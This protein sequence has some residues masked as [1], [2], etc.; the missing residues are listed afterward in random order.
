[1]E[2][3]RVFLLIILLI[4]FF[5]TPEIRPPT[6]SQREEISRRLEEDKHA[7]EVLAQSQYGDLDINKWLNITGF[8]DVDGYGWDRFLEVKQRAEAIT[9]AAIGQRYWSFYKASDQEHV[10]SDS[11]WREEEG[12]LNEKQ[13]PRG[14]EEIDSQQAEE[15]IS[16]DN[17][18][19]LYRNVTGI[20]HGE[21]MRTMLSSP[22]SPP[23]INFTSLNHDDIYVSEVFD[24]NITGATGKVQIRLNEKKGTTLINEEGT[25]REIAAQLSISDDTSYGDGWK[26]A[27]YG[28]H[29]TDFGGMILVSTSDK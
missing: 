6:P 10:H 5:A 8:R 3:A 25:V 26:V 2:P 12:S 4:F 23:Q 28:V 22:Y 15:E 29:F 7:T 24:R 17:P 14:V 19:P 20:V 16:L 1:M 11:E 21:W 13:V 27:L 18:L 9:E